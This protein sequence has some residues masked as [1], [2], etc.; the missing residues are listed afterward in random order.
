MPEEREKEYL[1]SLDAAAD[2][3][4]LRRR[5]TMPVAAVIRPRR[6]DMTADD[7]WK[8]AWKRGIVGDVE[9]T[10]HVQ[11]CRMDPAGWRGWLNQYL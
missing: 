11:T 5:V 7:I 4:A 3:L 8:A 6:L 2:L 9:M 1:D 10:W